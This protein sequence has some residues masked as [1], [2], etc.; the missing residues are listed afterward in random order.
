[1]EDVERLHLEIPNEY[2]GLFG[3]YAQSY[4]TDRDL[5]EGFVAWKTVSM[6]TIR[7]MDVV[8]FNKDI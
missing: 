3:R 5:F 7:T 1:M 2:G 4:L 8:E 6:G